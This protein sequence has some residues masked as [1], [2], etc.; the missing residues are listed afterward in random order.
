MSRDSV[1]YG[2]VPKRCRQQSEYN[3]ATDTNV[4]SASDNT[5]RDVRL[6]IRDQRQMYAL[7]QADTEAERRQ[8]ELYDVILMVSQAHH[9]NCPYTDDNM[10][11]VSMMPM[12]FVSV[13]YAY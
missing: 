5:D 8:L 7:I 11:N 2:R 10:K 12:H 4:S 13:T 6:Y 1:R 3:Q 9:C